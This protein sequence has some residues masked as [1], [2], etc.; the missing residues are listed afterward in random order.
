MSRS[1]GITG[2]CD[3]TGAAVAVVAVAVVAVAVVAV[4]S[5]RGRRMCRT[6]LAHNVCMLTP[7]LAR[8][9]TR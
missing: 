3:Q 7:I 1:P 6:P 2:R 9:S 4:A 8:R 5:A